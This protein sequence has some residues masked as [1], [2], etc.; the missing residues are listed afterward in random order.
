MSWEPNGE[1]W[2]YRKVCVTGGTGFLG[3][4]LVAALVDLGADVVV[5]VRDQPPIGPIHERWWSKVTRV[6]GDIRDQAFIE[7]VLGEAEIH[8]VF[9]LAA[10]TQ[11]GVANVNPV[12]SFD[13][14]IRG[15]WSVLEAVRRSPLVAQTVVASSDKAYGTQPVLPYTEAMPL[16]ALH[17]YD[18]SKAAGDMVAASYAHTFGVNVTITRCGNFYGPGDTNWERLFPGTIRL[19]LEGK[20]PIIRSDGT[21][22]RDYLYVEDGASSYLQLAEAMAARPELA[23]EAFNFSAE[24][25]LT[26]LDVVALMQEAVGTSLEPD[27]RA[28]ASGEI[29]HQYLSAAK[30][31]RELNWQPRYTFEEG[32]ALTIAWYRAVLAT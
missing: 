13:S 31:L 29:P 6:Q 8:T 7:R 24:R 2:R 18:V 26:V 11:V 20:R 10:Q 25:P 17:P 28:T 32:L 15:T 1:F 22:T 16:S 27:I 14:N 21:L 5:V 12:S 9:H 30:A 19:L 23:G 4:H 3:S